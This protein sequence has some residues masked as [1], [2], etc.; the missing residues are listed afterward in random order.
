MSRGRSI[1]CV[2]RL[3]PEK[4]G[5]VGGQVGRAGELGRN[6]R[7]PITG[8]SLRTWARPSAPTLISASS[9]RGVFFLS[10]GGSSQIGIGKGDREEAMGQRWVLV[11][12]NRGTLRGTEAESPEGEE[13]KTS[14]QESEMTNTANKTED[15][16]DT[17]SHTPCFFLL[18][19]AT[20]VFHW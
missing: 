12:S 18:F 14:E 17:L 6:T 1:S 19:F 15:K 4:Q 16:D 9:L 13:R 20:N 11:G 8:H 5:P 10:K 2:L 3:Y 7:L